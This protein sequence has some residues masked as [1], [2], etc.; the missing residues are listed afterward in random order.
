MKI[1]AISDLH[2]TF[3]TIEASDFL[4]IAGDWSDIYLQRNYKD[5][6]SWLNFFCRW[7]KLLPVKYVVMIAGNHDFC[8]QNLQ[9][10][11]DFNN[12]L[13]SLSLDNK[14]FY[15]ERNSIVLEGIKF[16]GIPHTIGLRGWAYYTEEPK[17]VFTIDED[18][19]DILITH[20][21][22]LLGNLGV[23]TDINHPYK[24]KECGCK[25][26]TD[27][28]YNNKFK[29]CFC[30]H[31]HSGDHKPYTF[32]KADGTSTNIYNVSILDENYYKRY[33][34]LVIDL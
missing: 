3:P 32:T 17:K 14:V 1:T 6:M 13:S 4:I 5:M 9:F 18:D 11:T 10:K 34:P 23:I 16:Y 7:L 12:L 21:P 15:L 26:L 22:P 2:G 28:I 27:L 20:Q 31:I 33:K 8:C 19:V 24:G 30:G 25:E 29:A